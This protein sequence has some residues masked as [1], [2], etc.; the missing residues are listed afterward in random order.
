MNPANGTRVSG[1]SFLYDA[2]T[3]SRSCGQSL[4]QND[5]EQRKSGDIIYDIACKSDTEAV[6][7]FLK[8]NSAE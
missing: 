7:P 8:Q 4:L 6:D 2:S 3:V 5:E 1:Y